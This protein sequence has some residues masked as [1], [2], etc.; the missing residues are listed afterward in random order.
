MPISYY[1]QPKHKPKERRNVNIK[2]W[3][4]KRAKQ[5]A[6]KYKVPLIKIITDAV[7]NEYSRRNDP[8]KRTIVID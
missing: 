4:Y 7:M 3:A 5:M 8:R 1:T 6:K 2:P